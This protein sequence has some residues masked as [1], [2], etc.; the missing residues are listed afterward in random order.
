MNPVILVGPVEYVINE[1]RLMCKYLSKRT[2]STNSF[3]AFLASFILS[4][5][6]ILPEVSMTKTISCLVS[7]RSN[8]TFKLT[9][10][11]FNDPSTL[12]ASFVSLTPSSFIV[13][14]TL[15][16]AFTLYDCVAEKLVRTT[17]ND[18]TILKNF[19]CIILLP[20]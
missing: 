8:S 4:N 2:A 17:N 20:F 18:N 11:S 19:F 16:C 15:S 12:L 1:I 14:A 7:D 13:V 10:H 5:S 6:F 3:A 9:S